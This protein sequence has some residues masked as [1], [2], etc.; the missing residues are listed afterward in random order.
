MSAAEIMDKIEH[1]PP[2][3][4]RVV[5]EMIWDKFGGDDLLTP[6]QAAE[7]DRRA[8]DALKHPGRGIPWEQLRDETLARLKR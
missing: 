3:E 6:E 7:L 4:Q 2:D 5:A 8:E 1:L